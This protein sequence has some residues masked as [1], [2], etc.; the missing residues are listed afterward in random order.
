MCVLSVIFSQ[1]TKLNYFKQNKSVWGTIPVYTLYGI[2]K[3]QHTGQNGFCVKY[4]QMLKKINFSEAIFYKYETEPVN[5]EA[6]LLRIKNIILKPFGIILD[7]SGNY[8]IN[9]KLF[10]ILYLQIYQTYLV[11][12]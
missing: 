1:T 2:T 10:Y 5:I 3:E 12:R 7:V 4:V 8:L 11:S 9:K 6:E